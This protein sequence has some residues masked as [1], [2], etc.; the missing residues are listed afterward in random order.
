MA[1]VPGMHGQQF[2]CHIIGQIHWL[3]LWLIQLFAGY[4]PFWLDLNKNRQVLFAI[5]DYI[6]VFTKQLVGRT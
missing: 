5:T 1:R 4:F 3:T 6:A 2:K